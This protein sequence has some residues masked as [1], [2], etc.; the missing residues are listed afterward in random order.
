MPPQMKLQKLPLQQV[1]FNLINNAVKHHDKTQGKVVVDAV[2]N[3]NEFV[4]SV[5]DDGPGIDPQFHHKIFEMFQTLQTREKSKGRGMG[6]ALVRK[7][8]IANGGT[9][10]LKSALGEGTLFRFTW[11][12]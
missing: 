12:K 11:P 4:F 9:I 8:I 10:S 5:C 2:E 3:A 7:I 6:L 1:L